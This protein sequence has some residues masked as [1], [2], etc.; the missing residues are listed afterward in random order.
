MFT[1]QLYLLTHEVNCWE[2]FRICGKKKSRNVRRRR[3]T[4]RTDGI[5]ETEC[6]GCFDTP[7]YVLDRGTGIAYE[8]RT[9]VDILEEA[10]CEYFEA[11]DDAFAREGLDA[12]YRTRNGHLHLQRA[13]AEAEPERFRHERLHLC[14]QDH[15]VA[16]YAHVD[17]ALADE[18]GYVGRWEEDA[19]S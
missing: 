18:G 17:V 16:C 1:V 3:G 6:A 14:F 12:L 13:L 19:V 15:V 4:Q 2:F 8:P 7:A 5:C 10:T 9:I 11:R